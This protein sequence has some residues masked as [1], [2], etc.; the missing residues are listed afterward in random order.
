MAGVSVPRTSVLMA[1]AALFVLVSADIR[2]SEESVDCATQ[3]ALA[4][5]A[6]PDRGASQF[7]HYC[8]RCHG[9]EAQG[10]AIRAYPVLVGQRFAYLVRQL[11]DFSGFQ[12]DSK[13]MHGVLTQIE[14]RGPQAW[15]DIAAYLNRLPSLKN[16]HYSYLVNQLHKLRDR[17]RHNVDATLVRFLASFEENDIRATGDYLSHLHGSGCSAQNYH[18]RLV[19]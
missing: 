4:L 11:A 18:G 2:A 8:A 15:V 13:T 3:A 9:S 12:R 17:Y 1:I 19:D 16:Q 10:D 5:D 14:S 7:A 6:H